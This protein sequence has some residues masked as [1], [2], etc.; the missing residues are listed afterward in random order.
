MNYLCLRARVAT[1]VLLVCLCVLP[2]REQVVGQVDPL[3]LSRVDAQ[4]WE[5]SS[6]LLL[7]MRT[8]RLA[9]TV[10]AFWDMMLFLKSSDNRKHAALF[11]DLAQVFW[12][13]YVDCVLSRNHG[14]GRRHITHPKQRITTT[15]A[16]ITD[17]SYVQES[18]SHLS[19]LKEITRDCF[20]IQVQQVGPHNFHHQTLP[21]PRVAKKRPTF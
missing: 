1:A 18:R 16:L 2:Q 15:R 11:W 13:M 4:C 9:D 6:A 12:D 21:K 7:E 3:S 10:P 5:S 14:M 20:Q 8:P 17:K 19:E